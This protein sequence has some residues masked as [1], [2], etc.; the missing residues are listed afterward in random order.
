MEVVMASARRVT[1]IYSRM[2]TS[3]QPPLG[4]LLIASVLEAEGHN[5]QVF[6]PLPGDWKFIEEI[7]SFNP[8]IVGISIMTMEYPQA[9][10]IVKTLRSEVPNAIYCAGGVHPTAL[11]E[12][13]INDLGLDFVVVGEGEYTM[14]EICANVQSLK[15]L[16]NVEGIVYKE[17]GKIIT[18]GRRPLIK[19]LDELPPPARYLLNMEWYLTPPGLVRGEFLKR[20]LGLFASRGC[21]YNCIFCGSNNIFGRRVR[22]RS[23]ANVIEELK[24]LIKQYDIDGY[25]FYDDTFTLDPKWV[26]DFC[27]ALREERIFLKWGCQVRVN[28]VSEEMLRSIQEAG[29]MQIDVGVESGSEKVLKNL[30]KGTTTE[31]IKRAFD[32][33]HKTGI[34]ALATFVVGSPGETMEDVEMTLKLAKEISPDYVRFFYLTPFPGS[35][36]YDMAKENRWFDSSI[37]FSADWDIMASDYSIMQINFTREELKKIRARL[38]NAFLISNYRKLLIREWK[39]AAIM[40]FTLTKHPIRFLKEVFRIIHTRRIDDIIDFALRLYR[41]DKAKEIE[42][43]R[44]Y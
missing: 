34:R 16:K 14:R 22:R 19:N 7:K 9:L 10:N 39:F 43:G 42:K 15:D 3:I 13:T 12:Q 29:C 2:N 17:N 38:Q 26:M 33:I 20:T 36:L 6:D 11:P 40:F 25:F 32:L 4:I 41:I 28:T 27:K 31:M 8:D 23:V 37:E 35:E 5:V 24:L 30:K 21:P 1:L 18:N 44:I